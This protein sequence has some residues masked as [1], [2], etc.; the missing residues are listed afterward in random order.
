MGDTPNIEIYE[1]KI[2]G[3]GAYGTVYL[4]EQIIKESKEKN[5]ESQTKNTESK[6]TIDNSKDK[7][8]ESKIKIALKEIPPEID[9]DQDAKNSLSNEIIVSSTL[10]NTNIV[11]MIDIVYKKNKRYLAYEYCNGGDLRFYIN[12]FKRFDEELVQ[13]VMIKMVNAL[14]ELHKKRVVHHDIKPENILIQ[15][16]PGIEETKELENRIDKI[17]KI[18]SLKKE[19]NYKHFETAQYFFNNYLNNNQL[20]MVPKNR[21]NNYQNM[22]NYYNNYQFFQNNNNINPCFQNIQNNNNFNQNIQNNNNINPCFQ[23]NNN[24]NQNIHNNNNFNQNIQNNNNFNLNN[25]YNNSSNMPMNFN[26]INNNLN[27]NNFNFNNMNNFNNNNNSFPMFNTNYP[28]WN[29]F[30]NINNQNNFSNSYNY[31]NANAQ[32]NY[33]NSQ[34][35]S[36]NSQNSENEIIDKEYILN[37]LKDA[38]FKLSDFGLSKLK[39]EINEKNLCGSPLY[40]A[41]ELLSKDCNIIKIEDPKVDIWALGVM[42]YEMFFG[43][44]P[45]QA[46]SIPKLITIFQDGEYH[47]DLRNIKEQNI[48]KELVEFIILCLQGDPKKRANVE[49]LKNSSFYNMSCKAFEKMEINELKKFFGDINN[50]GN[51]LSLSIKKDY[52]EIFK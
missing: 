7:N 43:N 33:I 2:L 4:G 13:I 10:D 41:P 20:M 30:N 17:K 9:N 44:R 6:S 25:Q 36:N 48:S 19:E 15:L 40:M 23:N 28:M 12:Y 39:T 18:I 29:I 11:R 47:M 26:Q 42:A 22:N 50:S 34:F 8:A 27:N 3:K 49:D 21:N 35:N 5:E 24:F 31:N 38:Q 16:Y 45:F 52:S 46:P 14:M 37:I 32:F 51:S 1:N